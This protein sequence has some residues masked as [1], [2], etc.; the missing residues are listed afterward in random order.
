M[1][2]TRHAEW[3]QEQR[4]MSDFVMKLIECYG[5]YEAAPGGAIRIY[6]GNRE[7]RTIVGEIKWQLQQ[8]DKARR[9]T[10]IVKGDHMITLY[11]RDL[12]G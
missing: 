5:R 12:E 11:R 7:Y 6:L 1:Q 2:K 4:G 9:G 8:L 10:L 3:R